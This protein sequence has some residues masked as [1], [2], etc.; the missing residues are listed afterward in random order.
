MRNN[1]I[2]IILITVVATGTIF[3]LTTISEVRTTYANQYKYHLNDTVP[4]I[5]IS[6]DF[7]VPDWLLQKVKS[8][9]IKDRMTV[10]EAN[11]HTDNS[12][13][14]Q[15]E[16]ELTKEE[17]YTDQTNI[18]NETKAKIILTSHKY[19]EN[20]DSNYDH[21]IGTVKN[22]GNGT[23]DYVKITFT[24]YDNNLNIVSTDYTFADPKT[25]NPGQK[26][27][28]SE[29]IDKREIQ[30]AANYEIAL[31]WDNHDGSEEYVENVDVIEDKK[32]SSDIENKGEVSSI[33]EQP[34]AVKNSDEEDDEDEDDED[35]GDD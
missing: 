25:L 6:S 5:T 12:N 28:F 14:S 18:D 26:S 32:P 13:I 29:M 21:I 1:F 27:P 19:V 24:F 11:L 9:V 15:I 20:D 30:N 35:D 23:A 10:A 22:I 7:K 8:D 3:Y 31:Q 16:I 17:T 33:I 4:G 34:E 2:N